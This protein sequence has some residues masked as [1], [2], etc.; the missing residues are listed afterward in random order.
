VISDGDNTFFATSRRTRSL[1]SGGVTWSVGSRIDQWMSEGFA[2]S[3]S[4]F[5]QLAMKDNQ[6]F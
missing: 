4:L 6:K 5:I 3:A 2:G 1:I